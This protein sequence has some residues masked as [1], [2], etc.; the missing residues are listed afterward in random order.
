MKNKQNMLDILEEI[1]NEMLVLEAP[2]KVLV[3]VDKAKNYFDDYAFEIT[4]KIQ[5]I[6]S[7]ACEIERMTED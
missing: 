7:L 1:K 4:D 6:E 2:R 5:D 3:L